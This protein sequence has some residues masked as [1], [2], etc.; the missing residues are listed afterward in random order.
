MERANQEGKNNIDRMTPT[1]LIIPAHAHLSAQN[2]ATV[3]RAVVLPI[4]NHTT[5]SRQ[6][7][8]YR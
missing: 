8:S 4:S 2:P 1:R 7:I 5:A 3:K 6:S